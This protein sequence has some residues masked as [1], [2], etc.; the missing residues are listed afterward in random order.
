MERL[1]SRFD[2]LV[3]EIMR[4]KIDDGKWKESIPYFWVMVIKI[5]TTFIVFI[6]FLLF[7][8]WLGNKG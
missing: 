6:I 7:W 1:P 2:I 5:L 8:I 3:P 4:E